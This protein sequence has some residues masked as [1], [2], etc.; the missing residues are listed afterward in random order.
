MVSQAN[1]LSLE[2]LIENVCT[3]H[4]SKTRSIE[5]FSHL[6]RT[7]VKPSKSKRLYQTVGIICTRIQCS[8]RRESDFLFFQKRFQVINQQTCQLATQLG[9]TRP[10]VT[11]FELCATLRVKLISDALCFTNVSQHRICFTSVL[12]QTPVLKITIFCYRFDYAVSAA[13]LLA[14]LN[15]WRFF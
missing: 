9:Q 2:Y 12:R 1:A 6:Y 13:D 5:R 8:R 15:L 3:K 7:V 14:R 11:I 10:A 4:Q